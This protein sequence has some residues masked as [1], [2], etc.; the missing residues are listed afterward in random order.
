LKE[1]IKV[2][3]KDLNYYLLYLALRDIRQEA[4]NS[5]KKMIFEL[6]NLFYTVPLQLKEVASGIGHYDDVIEGIYKTAK[7]EPLNGWLDKIIQR[8][9]RFPGHVVYRLLHV[10]M[11]GMRAEVHDSPNSKLFCLLDLFHIIPLQLQRVLD[12][13][14]SYQDI[15]LWLRE[16]ASLRGC[17]DWLDQAISHSSV[18]GTVWHSFS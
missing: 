17:G 14:G 9:K 16:R 3:A 2:D 5:D 11:V 4:T 1:A 13:E 15:T 6:A 7:S 8:E 12:G 10:A 18:V